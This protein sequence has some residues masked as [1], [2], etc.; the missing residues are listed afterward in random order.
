MG[1]PPSSERR[2]RGAATRLRSRNPYWLT[3][4]AKEASIVARR[5]CVRLRSSTELAVH[6]G[7]EGWRVEEARLLEPQSVG[8][9]KR[10]GGTPDVAQVRPGVLAV[11][12]PLRGL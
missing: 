5:N 3:P 9:L 4:R 8:E 10:A 2:K 11:H 1:R 7:V 12:R 6:R